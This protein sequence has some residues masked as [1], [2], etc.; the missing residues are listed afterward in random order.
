M[1]ADAWNAI[2]YTLCQATPQMMSVESD[3][4]ERLSLPN[5]V[6]PNIRATPNATGSMAD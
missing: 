3:A 5:L 2:E 6:H 1:Y 4:D